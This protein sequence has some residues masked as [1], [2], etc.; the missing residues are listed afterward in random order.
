MFLYLYLNIPFCEMLFSVCFLRSDREKYHT[1]F[2]INGF[3]DTD[4]IRKPVSFE[5]LIKHDMRVL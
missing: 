5:T 2:Q 1:L 3:D 4:K